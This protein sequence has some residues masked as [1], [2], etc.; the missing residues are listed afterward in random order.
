MSYAGLTSQLCEHTQVTVLLKSLALTKLKIIPTGVPHGSSEELC[1]LKIFSF[2][3]GAK[4]VSDKVELCPQPQHL[5][6]Y[7]I[8]IYERG[9]VLC[10]FEGLPFI[11]IVRGNIPSQIRH[12]IYVY[13]TTEICSK[14]FK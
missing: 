9:V 5:C 11:I 1:R 14:G 6:H 2:L 8:Y 13:V 4:L 10:I 7:W 12:T 3:G